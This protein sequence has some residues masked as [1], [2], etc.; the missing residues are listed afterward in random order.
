MISKAGKARARAEGWYAGR[1]HVQVLALAALALVW[2]LMVALALWRT[3]P[4]HR[5]CL[6]AAVVVVSL[7]SFLV[8]RLVS[9]HQVDRVLDHKVH[10][11]EP[12]SL[13]ELAGCLLVVL[14]AVVT[15]VRPG[16]REEGGQVIPG[17]PGAHGK[18]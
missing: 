13:I 9:L 6:P 3:R 14:V 18:V 15:S 17:A 10:G 7:L 5:H 1:H 16:A 8:V 4:S 12:G 11:A 2:L